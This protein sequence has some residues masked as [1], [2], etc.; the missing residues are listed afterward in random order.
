MADF[1]KIDEL[2][3]V[4][5]TEETRKKL[6]KLNDSKSSYIR[7]A[8]RL[9]ASEEGFSWNGKSKPDFL[10]IERWERY[11]EKQA[12]SNTGGR[13]NKVDYSYLLAFWYL[14]DKFSDLPASVILRRA[15]LNF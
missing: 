8:I 12:I 14:E 4:K 1:F 5:H 10:S 6:S 15:V 7:K 13:S 9:F 3:A 2:P 11:K